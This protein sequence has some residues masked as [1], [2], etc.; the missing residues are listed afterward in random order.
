M[1]SI[2]RMSAAVSHVGNLIL[3]VVL[4]LF[5]KT[6][7]LVPDIAFICQ[8]VLLPPYD[9]HIY[10]RPRPLLERTIA[11]LDGRRSNH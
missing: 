5:L 8:E 6:L 10:V 4:F 1:N 11:G 2:S 9:R 3:L 7:M